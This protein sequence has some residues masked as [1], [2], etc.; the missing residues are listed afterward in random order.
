MSVS[1]QTLPPIRGLLVDVDGTLAERGRLVEGGVEALRALERRGVAHRFVTNMTSRPR[2]ALVADLAFNGIHPWLGDSDIASRAA[3]RTSLR[4]IGDLKPA[5][6]VPGHKVD[7]TAADSP[8][9][10]DFMQKYLTDYDAIMQSAE[11]PAALATAMREKYP[12]L[13]IPALMGAGGRNFKK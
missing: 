12:D 13:K 2:S 6:V 7:V 4:R 10:L 8:D 1:G 3:W 11:T 5:I 9:L